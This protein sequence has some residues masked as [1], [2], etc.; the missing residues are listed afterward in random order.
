MPLL[1]LT[2]QPAAKPLVHLLQ[3]LYQN[4]QWRR[5]CCIPW[6]SAPPTRLLQRTNMIATAT[7]V[8]ESCLHVSPS[9]LSSRFSS[10]TPQREEATVHLP[11]TAAA[12]VSLHLTAYHCIQLHLEILTRPQ[13]G[14]GR[15]LILPAYGM[16]SLVALNTQ[17]PFCQLDS[18]D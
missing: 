7:C 4:I 18:L 17:T 8:H 10:P 6:V 5:V 11:D 13:N 15:A 3:I 12:T 14:Q 16:A 2:P 1:L 9:I